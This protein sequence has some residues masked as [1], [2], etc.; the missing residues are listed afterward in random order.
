MKLNPFVKKTPPT[1]GRRRALSEDLQASPSPFAYR[2]QRAEPTPVARRQRAPWWQ[3]LT[4]FILLIIL[5]LVAVEVLSLSNQAKVLPLPGSANNQVFLRPMTDYQSAAN[6]ILATSVW[7]R[8]K[9]TLNSRQL[10]DQLRAQFPELAGVSVTLPLL[11]HQPLVYVEPARPA[12]L[13]SA[14]NGFFVIADNGRALARDSGQPAIKDL[15][16][17]Q[18][19]DQSGLRVSLNRQALPA[20]EVS[21]IKTVLAE[22][23][24]KQFKVADMTLPAASSE[25]DIHVSGQPYTVKFNLH[26]NNPREQAGT[27]LAVQANLKRQNITPAQYV[28]VRLAGRAYYQ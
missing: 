21:F 17:P 25:L 28:D 10:G 8:S 26:D 1:A 7:N 9:L 20:G 2:S 23:K 15:D 6:Q 3:R 14:S 12:L 19:N 18:L 4:L 22:L 24:P 5:L 27:F 16:L 13:L 11:S